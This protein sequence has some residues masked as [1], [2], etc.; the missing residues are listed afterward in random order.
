MSTNNKLFE[1]MLNYVF[2]VEFIFKTYA[3]IYNKQ[4]TLQHFGG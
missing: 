1:K 3:T 2:N 4:L